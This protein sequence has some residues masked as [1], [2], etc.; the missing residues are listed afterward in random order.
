MATFV[1]LGNITDAGI[2]N[3][4][5]MVARHKRAVERAEQRGGKILASYALLG[6]YDYLVILEAPDIKTAMYVVTREAHGGNVR[7]QTMPAIPMEEFA[8][9][10]QD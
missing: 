5:S 7:Y 1:A 3:L 4:E 9:L 10:V 8:E 6:Q 2:Q